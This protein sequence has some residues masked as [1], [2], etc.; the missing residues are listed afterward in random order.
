MKTFKLIGKNVPS[1]KNA[2]QWTGKMLI[3]N[4]LTQ[5][6]YKWAVPKLAELKP[7][8]LSELETKEKPYRFHY[9][10]IRDSARRWDF[11]NIV[12]S[13]SDLLVKCNV[14][15]DDNTKVYIPIYEG[16]ELTRD[17]SDAGCTFWIE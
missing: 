4:K 8:I 1:S 16:E 14:I 12:Q 3:S 9:T 17:K 5:D 11:A 15:P 7:D 6:Y 10:F 13:I 2:K